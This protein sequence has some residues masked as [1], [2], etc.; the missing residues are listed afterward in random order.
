MSSRAGIV[1]AA[2]ER[3]ELLTAL[4]AAGLDTNAEAT[5]DS[6]DV[7]CVLAVV[8]HSL[9]IV[10]DPAGAHPRN[11]RS[12]S[13]LERSIAEHGLRQAPA[14]RMRLDL[15]DVE[16]ASTARERRRAEY[17]L[18]L[19]RPE[20]RTA[21]ARRGP[22]TVWAVADRTADL[23]I[24]NDALAALGITDASAPVL[25]TYGPTLGGDVARGAAP[26]GVV[27]SIETSVHRFVAEQGGQFW[28]PANSTIQIDELRRL[29]YFDAHPEQIFRLSADLALLPA[30][31]LGAFKALEPQPTLATFSAA[32]FRREPHYDAATGRLPSYTCRE[33]LWHTSPDQEPAM[34][35]G[36]E[37]M[38]ASL[39]DGLGLRWRWYEASDPFFLE[40]GAAGRK[41]ELLAE[42]PNGEIAVASVNA[43]GGHFT[44][45]GYGRE[46]M[47]T[48]CAGIGLERWVIAA[49]ANK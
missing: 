3:D 41:R 4:R 25:S 29:G 8:E 22:L 42:T 13:A 31:C 12:A 38:L 24:A 11:L 45:R 28:V 27:E 32:V 40:E 30:A 23:P 2:D 14:V 21:V 7:A 20:V 6:L 18:S 33:L 1:L 36:V 17:R 43:H 15:A 19:A 47:S 26:G 34:A 46:D 5:W 39:A 35:A 16:L 49:G 48:G 44:G 37:R 10:L 9:G